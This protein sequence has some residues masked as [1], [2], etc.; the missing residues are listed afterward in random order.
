MT[1]LNTKGLNVLKFEIIASDMMGVNM[2]NASHPFPSA[3]AVRAHSEVK[4]H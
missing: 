2:P 1:K 3:D 4:A